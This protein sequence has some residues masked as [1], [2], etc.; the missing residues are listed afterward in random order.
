MAENSVMA[1]AMGASWKQVVTS[2]VI[3][4]GA[5]FVGGAVG[6]AFSGGDSG[7]AGSVLGGAIAG[8]VTAGITTP[9]LGGNLGENLLMGVAMGALGGAVQYSLQGTNPVSQNAAGEQQ[10]GGGSG[11]DQVE[12]I[13]RR[14][15]QVGQ[16]LELTNEQAATVGGNLWEEGRSLVRVLGA[17][18][19]WNDADQALFDTWFGDTSEATRWNVTEGYTEMLNTDLSYSAGN[20]RFDPVTDAI[21]YVR[22]GDPSTIYLGQQYFDMSSGEAPFV[23]THELSHFPSVVPGGTND[24]TY[25]YGTSLGLAHT[26]DVAFQNASTWSFYA[27]GVNHSSLGV[28]Q[29]PQMNSF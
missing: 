14:H 1:L 6:G 20:F 8:A 23:L 4:I 2:D 21:A 22:P 19:R 29:N 5:M 15:A 13:G 28:F 27:A 10:G 11:A 16:T 18:D 26:P 9:L 24:I 25:D 12:A 7:M 17:L 3:S